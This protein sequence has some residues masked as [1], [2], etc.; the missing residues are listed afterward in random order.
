MK[1][2]IS[3]FKLRILNLQNFKFFKIIFEVPRNHKKII[4]CSL[5]IIFLSFPISFQTKEPIVLINEIMYD[6][7]GLDDKR[8]WIEIFNISSNEIDIT[9]WK[10]YEGGVNH[11]LIAKQECMVIPPQGYAIIADDTTAFFKGL[12]RL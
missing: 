3:K 1:L 7:S 2:L 9:G 6:P 10:F 4:Y 11:K 5:I 12:F 8:E